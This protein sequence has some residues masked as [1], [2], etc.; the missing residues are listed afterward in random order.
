MGNQIKRVRTQV[1]LVDRWNA[2][3]PKFFKALRTIGVTLAAISGV[4]IGS[5]VALPPVLISVAGYVLVAGGVMSA[6]SQVTV[7][8][9]EK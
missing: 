4:I 9:E 5:P 6:V 7:A 3:T 1:N 8:K 2:P